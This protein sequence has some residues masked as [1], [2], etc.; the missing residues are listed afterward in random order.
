MVTFT[1]S[2]YQNSF[3]SITKVSLNYIFLWH[4]ILLARSISVSYTYV[5]QQM[6]PS[7]SF[8]LL[9][10]ALS[11]F[12]K[13]ILKI[14]RLT[15]LLQLFYFACLGYHLYLTWK[16]MS[17]KCYFSI[18]IIYMSEVQRTKRTKIEHCSVEGCES[19]NYLHLITIYVNWNGWQK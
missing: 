10:W 16:E 8:A 13:R 15:N 3:T 19:V 9:L 2:I 1:T 4:N 18:S 11:A 17:R 5:T 12:L 14:V 6:W 7:L